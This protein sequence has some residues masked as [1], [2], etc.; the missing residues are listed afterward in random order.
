MSYPFVS[1]NICRALRHEFYNSF[2][3][4]KDLSMELLDALS[5]ENNVSSAINLSLSNHFTRQHSSISQLISEILTEEA[6]SSALQKIYD[7]VMRHI[8]DQDQE[9][10]KVNFFILD[11]TGIFKPDANS[12][13]DRSY[14]HGASKTNHTIGVGHSYSYLVGDDD[15]IGQW[16]IPINARRV[17]SNQNAIQLGFEQFK[18]QLPKDVS[19]NTHAL[20]ADSKYSSKEAI[21]NIYGLGESA[22]LLTRLNS[23]RTLH[24][25]YTG[26]QK[27]RGAKKKYGEEFK[28]H[29]SSTWVDPHEVLE[30]DMQSARGRDYTVRLRRWNGLI[31][32]GKNGISMHDKPFDV[33]KVEVFDGNGNPV[34]YKK[35]WLMVAGA[36]KNLIEIKE[37]FMRYSRRFKIEHFFRFC[38]QHLLLGKYQTPDTQTQNKWCT[39]SCL[40]YLNLLCLSGM[41]DNDMLHP[42]R[43]DSALS[44]SVPSPYAVKRMA[45]KII[46][47]IGTPAKP[48]YYRSHGHG[49]QSGVELVKR[50]KKTVH[51]K[52]KAKKTKSEKKVK[53]SDCKKI[54]FDSDL[55]VIDKL[56]LN[57][58]Q[59]E[60]LKKVA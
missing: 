30:F 56:K 49:R 17:K 41:M 54:V 58:E 16:V 57:E 25:P 4:R 24:F 12:M 45:S 43:K 13:D 21:A 19:E 38:K 5:S 22:L 51:T 34:N 27:Q 48:C 15:A 42:W 60:L 18:S 53:L 6:L 3:S 23:K 28:L 52:E 31:L 39:F 35:M 47:K 9:P 14:V 11:E 26:E 32:K 33:V 10:K 29:D 36:R 40:A 20:T 46:D 8:H 50:G 7:L 44:K 37:V 55:D 59:I 1:E 2:E